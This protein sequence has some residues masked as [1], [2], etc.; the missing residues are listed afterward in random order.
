MQIPV[1]DTKGQVLEQIEISEGV[2]GVPFN[3]SVVHQAMVRQLANARQGTA[4]SKTRGQVI[5]STRKL[6]RQKGTGRARR[7]SMNSPV[8]KGGGVAFGPHP[9]S[10]RQAMPKKMRR[11]ALRCMLS[12]KVAEDKLIVVDGLE[13]SQPK[14]REM[15]TIL[16][17][18][19][20][21]SS[22]LI[23]TPER[24]NNVIKSCCNLRGVEVSQASLLNAVALLSQTFLI[25]T[26]PALRLVENIWDSQKSVSA[27]VSEEV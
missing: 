5:G 22:V 1:H 19:G 18:L 24:D 9:R 21:D 14:V 23:V 20:V 17:S 16:Q 15:V 12:A 8:L 2:F 3:Q 10:Y 26:L 11:Q 13:L 25:M 4:D 7:G 6:Y 27:G